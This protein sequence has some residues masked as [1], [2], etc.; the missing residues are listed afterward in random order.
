[1][2]LV[3]SQRFESLNDSF[4]PGFALGGTVSE[5]FSVEPGSGTVSLLP[6]TMAGVT[7]K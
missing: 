3:S 5:T 7:V 6:G 4:E 1:M 2:T